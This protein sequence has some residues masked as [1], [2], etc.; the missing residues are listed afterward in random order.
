MG[1]WNVQRGHGRGV[2]S[3]DWSGGGGGE[4]AGCGN[5][6]IIEAGKG[7]SHL[8]FFNSEASCQPLVATYRSCFQKKDE[9]PQKMP[10]TTLKRDKKL[11]D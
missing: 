11:Q 5:A 2:E 10:E 4:G 7:K 8:Q 1:D 3:C 9:F 6:V